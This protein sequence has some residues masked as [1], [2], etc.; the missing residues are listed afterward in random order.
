[1]FEAVP[2]RALVPARDDNAARLLEWSLLPRRNAGRHRVRRWHVH[3]GEQPLFRRAV[4][5][6][7]RGLCVLTWH[8]DAGAVRRGK[9]RGH[10][11]P[12]GR[13]VHR[14]VYARTLLRRGQHQQ[15]VWCVPCGEVQPRHFQHIFGSLPINLTRDVH[16][17]SRDER[18]H[19]MRSR[20]PSALRRPDRL[21]PVLGGRASSKPRRS[22][23]F[24]VPSR[25]PLC[26]RFNRMQRLRRGLL[27]PVRRFARHAVHIL[28]VHPGG[29]LRFERNGGYAQPDCRLLAPLQIDTRDPSL[30]VGGELEPLQRRGHRRA[31]G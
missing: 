18:P 2:G 28:R 29:Q 10:S 22:K 27:P 6:L 20:S 31:R 30:Q 1:M 14:S 8:L 3:Q 21:H 11:R 16:A 25:P 7:P 12:D 5:H 23:L 17:S 9:I 4:R 19:E 26:R 13:V 15:H 24:P